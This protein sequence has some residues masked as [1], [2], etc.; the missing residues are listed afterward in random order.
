MSDELRIKVKYET[1]GAKRDLDDLER[2]TQ[3]SAEGQTSFLAKS[4][5][6][7]VKFGAAATTLAYAPLLMDAA[8]TARNFA[9]NAARLTPGYGAASAFYKKDNAEHESFK[10]F[11]REFGLLAGIASQQGDQKTIDSLADM[12][13]REANYARTAAEGESIL[14]NKLLS[15]KAKEDANYAFGPMLE[16]LNATLEKLTDILGSFIP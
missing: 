6:R 13:R 10:N 7:A 9:Q 2:H 16:K 5:S 3:R 8:S 1:E 12:A 11:A 15:Q 14:T 4:A